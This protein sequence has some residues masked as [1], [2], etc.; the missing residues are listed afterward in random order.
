MKSVTCVIQLKDYKLRG[1]KG[2]IWLSRIINRT[3]HPLAIIKH[4]KKKRHVDFEDRTAAHELGA[5]EAH[6]PDTHLAPITSVLVLEEV[7][8]VSN[9][10]MAVIAY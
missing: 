10:M 5:S 9:V 3:D 7:E 6:P 1:K 8:H 2:I 4:N